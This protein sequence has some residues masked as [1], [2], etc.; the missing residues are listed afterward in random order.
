MNFLPKPLLLM[1]ASLLNGT[2]TCN[3]RLACK[4]CSFIPLNRFR[5]K[6]PNVLVPPG[7]YNYINYTGNDYEKNLRDCTIKKLYISGNYPEKFHH[8]TIIKKI[9][10]MHIYISF[11]VNKEFKSPEFYKL[12]DQLYGSSSNGK[13]LYLT[14]EQYENVEEK[15]ITDFKK[16]IA[17]GNHEFLDSRIKKLVIGNMGNLNLQHLKNLNSLKILGFKS[18]WIYPDNLKKLTITKVS[19]DKLF[20]LPHGLEK[21]KICGCGLNLI[22]SLVLPPA[23]KL[24]KLVIEKNLDGSFKIHDPSSN[25][26]LIIKYI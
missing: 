23:L 12:E 11:R 3:L 22:Q 20:G 19:V 26:R 9:A 10:Y 1:I 8:S 7:T 6:I 18:Q 21:L 2:N 4:K 13:N 5:L 16:I 15:K 17:V 25:L 24:L 14:L